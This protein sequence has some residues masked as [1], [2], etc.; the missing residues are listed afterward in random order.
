MPTWRQW[1]VTASY[2]KST[3][4]A[5]TAFTQ[6]EYFRFYRELLSDRRLTA[7]L[8]HFGVDLEFFPHY[9]IRPQLHNFRI[10][11][12]AIKVAD[13]KNRNVQQAMKEC[14]LMV[15]DYSSVFFDVAY[16]GIPL[17]YVPFDEEDFYGRHYKRGYFNLSADGFGPVCR[18]V[19][20]A[21]DEIIAAM[22]RGFAVESPYL[23]RV[24]QFFAHRGGGNC[25]RVFEAIDALGRGSAAD[26][27]P[28]GPIRALPAGRVPRER[29]VVRRLSAEAGRLAVSRVLEKETEGPWE[30]A[31]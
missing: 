19:D 9:E 2:K 11:S 5:K 17:V 16:M 31:I 7:A 28:Q 23:E 4:P 3:G 15:T 27:G 21:V 14:S 1:I 20:Q 22:G 25:E 26:L 10:D 29:E 18:T 8:E 12:S 30:S 6:S 13:P 24:E